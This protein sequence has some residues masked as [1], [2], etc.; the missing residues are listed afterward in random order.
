MGIGMKKYIRTI[1]IT[2]IM[3]MLCIGFFMYLSNR[4]PSQTAT[5]KDLAKQE[6]DNLT[7]ID[8][9]KNYPESPKEVIKLYARI[10]KAYYKGNLTDAQIEALGKQA[11][12]LFDSELKGTQT[13][14]EFLKALKADI[15]SYKSAGRYVS[16][17]SIEDS[18]MVNYSTFQGR[19]YAFIVMTYTLRENDK[20]IVSRTKYTLRQDDKGRWKILFW[21][22]A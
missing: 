21:E 11:R 17:Y 12:I 8:I 20:L 14:S 9:E 19:K 1:F 5:E 10:T 7:T 6:V 15:E 22:L 16:D 3:A 13:D 2:A 4:E 18:A